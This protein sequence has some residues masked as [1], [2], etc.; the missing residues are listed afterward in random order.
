MITACPGQTV[1]S[2]PKHKVTGPW[3]F[4]F[5]AFSKESARNKMPEKVARAVDFIFMLG[6]ILVVV[7]TS[8]A[9]A[10]GWVAFSVVKIT[11]FLSKVKFL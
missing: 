3:A 10:C 6:C 5:E 8:N 9:K 4:E 1:A 2:C 11:T 7:L